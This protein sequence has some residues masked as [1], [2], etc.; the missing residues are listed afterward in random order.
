[1]TA[2]PLRLVIDTDPG[3]DDAISLLMAL[4]HPAAR[5]EAIT[6]LAGNVGLENTVRNARYLVELCEADVPVHAGASHA[7]LREARRASE[8]HGDDGLGNRRARE[9]GL[10]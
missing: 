10:W 5:V 4:R 7:L 8:V 1:M 9:R 6:V 3:V 2:P